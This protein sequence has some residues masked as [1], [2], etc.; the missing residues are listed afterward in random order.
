MLPI[1]LTGI[2]QVIDGDEVV[3]CPELVEEKVFSGG[4]EY[5]CP[6]DR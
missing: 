5:Q 4:V 3:P 1:D 2:D 6:E